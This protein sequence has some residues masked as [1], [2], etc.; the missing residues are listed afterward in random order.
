[1]TVTVA[2]LV[3]VLALAGVAV[4]AWS[5]SGTGTS[6]SK[7]GTLT[8]T[9]AAFGTQSC[10]NSTTARVPLT[11]SSVSG[12]TAY[13]V[14][15]ASNS[16]FTSNTG[17]GRFTGTSTSPNFPDTYG[18]VYLRVTTQAGDSWKGP[19]SSTVSARVRSC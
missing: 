19:V 4:A 8:A 2:A 7:A 3:A 14:E 18:T 12:A 11:W 5:A 13:F 6:R 9:T 1:M 17:S 10:V 15:I 16:S